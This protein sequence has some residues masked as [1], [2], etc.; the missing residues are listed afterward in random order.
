VTSELPSTGPWLLWTLSH[1]DK[2][3]CGLY[4]MLLICPCDSVSSCFYIL[5]VLTAIYSRKCLTGLMQL[6]LTKSAFF[7]LLLKS[8]ILWLY[9]KLLN[10]MGA[11]PYHFPDL[12]NVNRTFFIQNHLITVLVK[13][14]RFFLNHKVFYIKIAELSEEHNYFIDFFATMSCSLKCNETCLCGYWL[15]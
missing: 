5:P 15:W 11:G 6:L 2:W 10:F 8:I 12:T 14:C 13:F 7:I 9:F 3:C 1:V 4:S